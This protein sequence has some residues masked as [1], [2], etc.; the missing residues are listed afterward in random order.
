M[1]RFASL[2]RSTL[3][4]VSV[5]ATSLLFSGKTHAQLVNG[6]L[7]GPGLPPGVNAEGIIPAGQTSSTLLTGWTASK[8]ENADSNVY[9]YTTN[10]DAQNG[11]FFFLNNPPPGFNYAVQLD[12]TTGN[13]TQEHFTQ[14]ASLSQALFLAPGTY[15]LSFYISTE[16]GVDRGVDKGGT[17]GVLVSLNGSGITS[18]SLTNAT[19]LTT[20]PVPATRATAPWT[21]ET[22]NF[23]VGTG[24]TVTLT[25][26]DDPNPLLGNNVRS[27]NI[28]LGGI[29]IAAIPEPA[30]LT[31]IGVGLVSLVG[32]QNLLKRRR[33]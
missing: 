6:D 5:L 18:G 17:S 2:S 8:S 32:F 20:S 11:A 13:G 23:T 28:G 22:A 19:F 25:F 29:S 4:I 31:L 27:S 21:S 33:A 26:Q 12:S 16:V 30:P 24:S 10:P 7:A 15:T 3:L 1:Q 14:G 9:Y